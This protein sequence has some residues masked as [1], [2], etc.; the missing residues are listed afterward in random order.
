MVGC[1]VNKGEVEERIKGGCRE[2]HKSRSSEYEFQFWN[3]WIIYIYIYIYK[4][5]IYFTSKCLVKYLSV[6][7]YGKASFFMSKNNL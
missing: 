3:I 2:Y 4:Y 5:N 6:L 7:C 1:K